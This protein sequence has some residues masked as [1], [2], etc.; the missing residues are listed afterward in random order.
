MVIVLRREL[1]LT[2][3][4]DDEMLGFVFQASETYLVVWGGSQK[5]DKISFLSEYVV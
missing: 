3:L 5:R 1:S 4:I 2:L